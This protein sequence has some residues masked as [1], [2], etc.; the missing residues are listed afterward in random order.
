MLRDI[1]LISLVL[2]VLVFI[3]F[4]AIS[5]EKPYNQ[6]ALIIIPSVVYLLLSMYNFLY[7]G[8][9]KIFKNYGDL[10]FVPV[11]AFL[12][13]QK[14]SF[15]ALLPF[16]SLNTSRK[17]FQGMLF[18]WLSFAFAFYHYG[19]LAFA[20][21]PILMSV[22]VASLHPDLVE[23]IRK[24]RFYIKNLRRSYSKMASDYGK[25]EKELLDLRTSALLLDKL[26]NSPSLVDYLRA[27]KEEFNVK[28]ISITPLY[29]S[30]S[31]EIDP[32]T[33]SFHVPVKLE[34]GEAKVSFYL[35][36][37]LELYDKQ[38]LENLEKAGKLI[39]LYIEGFEENSKAKVIAV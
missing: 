5:V 18:L 24:E 15:L 3:Y 38:L 26:Q 6:K 16:I 25:L 37:P 28:S 11:L 7:P 12:S 20:L 21:L 23:A 22:Y 30:S 10:L 31:K 39:N 35:N 33:C 13:G 19:K 32:S 17:V 9:L 8:R 4:I 36:N 29:G 1:A 27:I 14:E 2:R 34:K